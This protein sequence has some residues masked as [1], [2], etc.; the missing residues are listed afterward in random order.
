MV[1]LLL[2][3][4]LKISNAFGVCRGAVE[5]AQR[6]IAALKTERDSLR[7][8]I[9]ADTEAYAN[10]EKVT[11]ARALFGELKEVMARISGKRPL[12]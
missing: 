3:V 4:L 11:I 9:K 6:E 7:A 10:K 8:A 1:G 12:W 5:G 2:I